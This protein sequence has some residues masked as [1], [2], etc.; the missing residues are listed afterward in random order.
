MKI[1]PGFTLL[2]Q[3]YKQLNAPFGKF[4]MSTLRASTKALASNDSND[5]T[6]NSIEGKIQSLTTRRDSLATEIK[7]VLEG[8]E[9]N[10][11]PFGAIFLLLVRAGALF[12]QAN[13][14]PH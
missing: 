6:Y 13:Q 12:V 10:G 14:L 1:S 9:F 5:A 8:A 2:A 11:Q 3:T 7:G 4:A